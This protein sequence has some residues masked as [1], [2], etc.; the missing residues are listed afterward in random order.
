MNQYG[1]PFEA[2]SFFIGGNAKMTDKICYLF[3]AGE[4]CGHPAPLS[5]WDFVIAADGGY[6]YAVSAGIVPDLLIGDFDSISAKPQFH[7]TISLPKMKD[8]TDMAAALNVGWERGFRT[9]HIY[10]GTGG[11]I[12]HTLANI[13]CVADIAKR[14]GKAFLMDKD[15]ILTAIHND[16][17]AFDQSASGI[18]SVFAFGNTAEG[19]TESGLKYPLSDAVLSNTHPIGISN[20]FIGT[21]SRISVNSGT[22]IITFSRSDRELQNGQCASGV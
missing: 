12:D 16:H 11:R 1:A 14:G 7:N 8:D 20:E 21:A 19:V 9:F 22:L 18:I 6:D 4:R 17:I 5:A 15:T 13:Q 10:G 3:G 2:A